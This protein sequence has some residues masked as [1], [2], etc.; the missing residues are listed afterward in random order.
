MESVF[1]SLWTKLPLFLANIVI[2]MLEKEGK[3]YLAVPA[4]GGSL[5]EA[6]RAARASSA[7]EDASDNSQHK[8]KGQA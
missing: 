5:A 6:G 3:G 4:Y 1:E 8:V 7:L 2:E